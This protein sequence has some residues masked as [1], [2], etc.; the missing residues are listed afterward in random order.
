MSEN[1][2]IGYVYILTNPCFKN[3]WIKIGYT[4]NMERRI[5]ELSQA[6]GVPLPFEAYAAIKTAKY[7]E[8]EKMIH[9]TI[10]S[11]SPDKRVNP[12]KEFFNILPD[13][14]LSMF[15]GFAGLMAD[16]EIIIYDENRNVQK[17]PNG[18]LLK[19]IDPDEFSNITRE[20]II[21]AANFIDQ[22][23]VPSKHN[24]IT[25]NVIVNDKEYPPKY[26]M[27]V[28]YFHANGIADNV[29][30]KT[31]QEQRLLSRFNTLATFP[32]YKKLNFSVE[33]KEKYEEEN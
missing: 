1:S 30:T 15:L 17:V 9:N 21:F 3:D 25:R 11:L 16:A 4:D 19:N 26:T 7:I 27:A 6:A 20:H 31:I 14:A 18:K 13:D 24:S 29:I 5:V 8:L 12:K 33:T 23:G 10:G 32:T 22:N 2:K 28:A